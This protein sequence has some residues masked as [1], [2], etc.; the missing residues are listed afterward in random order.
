MTIL[1]ALKHFPESPLRTHE[2]TH[3]MESQNLPVPLQN[4]IPYFREKAVSG[5][6]VHEVMARFHAHETRLRQIYAQDTESHMIADPYSNTVPIF[7]R[8]EHLLTIRAR[9]ADSESTREQEQYI[10]PLDVADRRETG[11]LA[12]VRSLV[13]FQRNFRIFSEWSLDDWHNIV[14]AGGAVT[15]CLLPV[16]LPH[17]ASDGALRY[18]LMIQVFRADSFANAYAP[19]EVLPQSSLLPLPILI[20]LSMDSMSRKRFRRWSIS[21]LASAVMFSAKPR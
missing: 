13:D 20:F 5:A 14:V 15:T 3:D 7:A 19:Q 4:F 8:Y 10:F 1:T 2:T 17:N 21:K 18:V 6:A 9:Q 12:V 16:P 11:S